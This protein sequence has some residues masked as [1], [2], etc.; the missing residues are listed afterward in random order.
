MIYWVFTDKV[1]W[2]S[3]EYFSPIF[4]IEVTS[5]SL[6]LWLTE[7]AKGLEVS[8]VYEFTYLRIRCDTER[9]INTLNIVFGRLSCL[10]SWFLRCLLVYVLNMVYTW[11]TFYQSLLR[12]VLSLIQDVRRLWNHRHCAGTLGKCRWSWSFKAR[13]HCLWWYR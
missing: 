10:G 12:Y 8:W 6:R 9:L 5:I 2:F 7:W 3:L 13:Q 11:F 4:I 1:T